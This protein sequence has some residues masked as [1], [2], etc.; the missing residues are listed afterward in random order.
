MELTKSSG[1]SCFKPVNVSVAAF[2]PGVARVDL[3]VDPALLI[4]VTYPSLKFEWLLLCKH[5]N[6]L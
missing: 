6:Q 1:F 4:R 2:L 3:E 5:P